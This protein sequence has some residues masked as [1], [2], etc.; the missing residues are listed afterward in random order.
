MNLFCYL[1]NYDNND[2]ILL[3]RGIKMNKDKTLLI[4]AAGMGSRF[5]GL[6][7]IEPIG[8]YGEFLIDY[9]IYD[10][11]IAGYTKVVFIIKEENYDIFRETVGKRIENKIKVEYAFQKL[12]DLPNGFELP[13]DRTKPWGTSHAILSAKNLINEQF[14]IINADDFYGRDAFLVASKFIDS[15]FNDY[16]FSV[17]GYMIKNVLSKNGAVKRGV[18]IEKN[19]LLEKLIERS[20]VVENNNIIA[21]P[22]DGSSSFKLNENDSV[23]MNMLTFT[24]K[25]FKY[26]E[27]Y[28]PVFL[29]LNKE[30]IL[31]CEYLIPDTVYQMI[32]EKKA[33]VKVLPTTA[34]WYGITYKEDKEEVIDNIKKLVKKG[35]YP[36][37]LWK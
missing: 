8:E 27:E 15:N 23:S 36:N 19:G 34:L 6:K 1:T 10:A 25:I 14:T 28:F 32:L 30:N 17:T 35:E 12:E 2:I 33:E 16:L 4:M 31:K 20:V 9:S 11:I 7:Q 26:L 24:P 3:E 37:N 13:K 21:S 18:C 29:N 22:L 5:G